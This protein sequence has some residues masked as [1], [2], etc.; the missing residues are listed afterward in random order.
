MVASRRLVVL[1]VVVI[2]LF[3]VA[4][5]DNWAQNDLDVSFH[6][7]QDTRSVTVL[8]PD[9]SLNKDFT[10]RTTVRARVGVDA[11]SAASDSCVR[12]HQEG[13][14]N[15]RGVVGVSVVRKYGDCKLTVG[16]EFSKEQFYAATTALTS[17]SRDLNKGNTTVAGGFSYSL[18]RPSSTRARRSSRSTRPTPSSRSPSRGQEDGHA[19]R[20]RVEPGQRLPVE[21]V[22]AHGSERRHDGRASA[23]ARTRHTFTA[24][25]RQALPAQTFLDADLRRYRDTWSIDSTAFSIGLSHH[26]GDTIVGGGSYRR[27]TQTGAY[28]YSPK[29]IGTP[30]Y[31]TGDFRLFP[32]DSNAFTGRFEITPKQGIFHMPTGTTLTLQ[33]ER[34][35]STTDFEAAVFTGG[36]RVPLK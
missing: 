31:Y 20:V 24:R 1:P 33:Y 21:P 35:R 15:S 36:F 19:V 13:A 29:Y 17:V 25:I 8:S 32:F 6:A 28:F 10:D 34:Y 22:S 26:F 9:I 14:T 18:N 2:A 7:F 12:C 3:L 4:S 23:G 5:V 16:G 27:Y 11:I 30:E